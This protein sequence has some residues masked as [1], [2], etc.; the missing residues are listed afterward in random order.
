MMTVDTTKQG[1]GTLLPRPN[2]LVLLGLKAPRLVYNLNLGWIFGH[3]ILVVTH[4]GRK[5]GLIH[6]TPL[7]VV[8]YDKATDTSIVISAWGEKSDW[9][10]N[11]QKT[12]ALQI[13][14]GRERYVPDQRVLS[15]DETEHELEV[16]VEHHRPTAKILSRVLKLDF[17]E[18]AEA[19]RRFAESARMVAF[20]PRDTSHNP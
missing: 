13:Q 16:Y 17:A 6:Q 7:E 9:Y 1:S 15:T 20:K 10:R 12:P 4:K 8:R 18:S 5:S 2:R 3:R 19:R 14:T 11:I